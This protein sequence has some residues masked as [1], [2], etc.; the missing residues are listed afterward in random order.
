VLTG[1]AVLA[2]ASLSSHGVTASADDPQVVAKRLLGRIRTRE[3]HAA[4]EMFHYPK[5]QSMTERDADRKSVALWLKRLCIE[6]G[7]LKTADALRQPAPTERL[8]VL[9]VAGG[10]VAY[11]SQRGTVTSVVYSFKTS[12]DREPDT[13]VNIHLMKT[14]DRWEIQSFNFAVPATRPDAKEFIGTLAR[15]LVP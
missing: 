11:W 4:A 8:L 5:T 3:F 13:R 10:D 12:F 7:Q 2:W 9:S 6:L 15:K 14:D 1:A